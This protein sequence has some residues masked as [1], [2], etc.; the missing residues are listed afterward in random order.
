MD[1]YKIPTMSE[2][3]SPESETFT[4]FFQIWEDAVSESTL[5]NLKDE[6]F[7]NSLKLKKD[8]I[9]EFNQYMNDIM[10]KNIADSSSRLT[11]DIQSLNKSM[12][13]VQ[14]QLNILTKKIDKLTN[15]K[16]KK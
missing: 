3:N 9:N 13:N 8:K 7:K 15:S 16:Q 12:E 10:S 11:E 6:L 14:Q 1:I 5:K 2:K 4:K